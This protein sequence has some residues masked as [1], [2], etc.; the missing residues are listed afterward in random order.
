M[1]EKEKRSIT[2]ERLVSGIDSGEREILLDKIHA[3]KGD[4]LILQVAQDDVISDKSHSLEA[5]YRNENFLYKI[6]VWIRSI[7]TKKST[8][9]LYNEDLLAELSRRVNR[10]HPGLIDTKDA[11]LLSLFCAKLKELRSCALFFRPYFTVVDDDPGRFYVFLSS[12]LAPEISAAVMK[13]SDPYNVPLDQT[14][15]SDTR[16]TMI[17]N[18]EDTLAHIEKDT[19]STLYNTIKS[20]NWL[21]QF[22]LLP[23][24]HFLSQFTSII[25][26]S[27][28]CPYTNAQTDYNDFAKVLRRASNISKEAMESLFLYPQKNNLM[29]DENED[30]DNSLREFTIKFKSCVGVIQ[31]FI[32]TVPVNS[33]GKIIFN[34]Y[35]WDAGECPGSESWFLKYKEEWRK[36]F[37][38]RWNEYLHDKKKYDLMSILQ[39]NYKLDTFP[40][41]PDR[42]WTRLWGGVPFKCEMT[43]GFIWWFA[44]NKF[45]EVNAILNVI[46]L[47]GIFINKENGAQMGEAVNEFTEANQEILSLATSLTSTGNIGSVFE[48]LIEEHMR[49]LR[50]QQTVNNLMNS[51]ENQVRNI[52]KIFCNSSRQ[53]DKILNGIL[54]D[55]KITGYESLQNFMTIGGRG[56]KKFRS[57]MAKT[58]TVLNT[59]RGII[60][61]IE[62]LD[63]AH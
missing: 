41:L 44:S 16:A 15:H 1:D 36:V 20:I 30:L 38:A 23:F 9:V 3:A 43:A 27:F 62:P 59:A 21:K 51:T 35:D 8:V 37:N 12:L 6:Y 10:A 47:E 55:A 29:Q 13:T 33:I 18:M 14:V 54:S 5:K 25:S 24:T 58:Q 45:K 61:E 22:T 11:L 53:I 42:P 19:K 49:T 31:T 26:S 2:F 57:D 46:I 48:K 39:T 40:E 52:G 60:A 50:S 28:T 17:K 34:D 32:Q 56:N 63:A 7:F 4:S